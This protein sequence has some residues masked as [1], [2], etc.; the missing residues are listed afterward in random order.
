MINLAIAVRLL[1][2]RFIMEYQH[3]VD[4]RFK[5]ELQAEGEILL[6]DMLDCSSTCFL[7]PCE[8]GL[9]S[10]RSFE[11]QP[12][13]LNQL[14]LASDLLLLVYSITD[15][16]SFKFVQK[17]LAELSSLKGKFCKSYIPQIL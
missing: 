11:L 2:N 14:V 16:H 10:N 3:G 7:T 4:L 6:L 9:L 5:H 13:Y 12:G 1:T 17:V 8:S 15:R